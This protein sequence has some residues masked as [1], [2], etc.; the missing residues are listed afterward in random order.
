MSR[1]DAKTRDRWLTESRQEEGAEAELW[2]AWA[3]WDPEPALL[4]AAKSGSQKAIHQMGI[5][6]GYGPFERQPYNTTH[7]GLNVVGH[8]DFSKFSDRDPFA[9]EGY[10]LGELW[11]DVDVAASARFHV[12]YLLRTH[13]APREKLIA[14]FSGQDIYGGEDGMIDRGF[15][16]LRV[17]AVI[18]PEEMKAW[19]ATLKDEEMEEALTWLLNHP[20]GNEP[21]QKREK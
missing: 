6:A 13:Y 7:F 18:A 2:N 17:W 3:A 1:V 19:I 14:F 15:C 12:D 4:T 5:N 20:W 11:G 9:D 10:T 8:F 16:A 21:E